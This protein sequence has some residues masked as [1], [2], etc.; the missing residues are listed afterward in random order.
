[1]HNSRFRLMAGFMGA[2]F[3]LFAGT[4]FAQNTNTTPGTPGAVA[5]TTALSPQ[6]GTNI[7]T[8]APGT[9]PGT[10]TGSANA[11][12]P[13]TATTTTTTWSFPGGVFGII[14]LAVLIFLA[15][16]VLLRGRRRTV[17]SETY[18]SS[19]TSPGTRGVRTGTATSDRENLNSRAASGTKTT[20]G[21]N[22]PSARL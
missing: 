21:T 20:S 16:V 5:G 22:D 9:Q 12:T 19:A 3:W 6:T 17:V 7:G 15:L 4:S 2:G 10:P 13:I 14:V 8:T 1:M 11:T 18:V